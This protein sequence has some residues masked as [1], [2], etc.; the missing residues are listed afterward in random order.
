MFLFCL[1]GFVC[2]FVCRERAKTRIPCR[3]CNQETIETEATKC[4]KT[5]KDPEPLCDV[6]AHRHTLKKAYKGHQM[7]DDLRMFCTPRIS[8]EYVQVYL[9]SQKCNEIGMLQTVN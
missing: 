9:N 4:C 2:F 5:C 3:P 6:C 1:F 7:T 8:S